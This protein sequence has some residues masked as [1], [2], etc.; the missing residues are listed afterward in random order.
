MPSTRVRKSLIALSFL[1]LFSGMASLAM[2]GVGQGSDQLLVQDLSWSDSFLSQISLNGTTSAG[3]SVIGGTLVVLP[4]EY[5][6]KLSAGAIFLALGT[7]SLERREEKVL[8]LRDR[9]VEEIS[10]N[11]GIHLR[12]L[13]RQVG[14][15]MGALQYHLRNL[16]RDGSVLSVRNG[17]A[18]HLFIRGYS[19][20]DQVLKLASMFTNPTIKSILD[21]CMAN[22]RITQAELSRTLSI[23]KSLVSYYVGGLLEED[24]LRTIK[25]FGREKP[26]V[27][28]DWAKSAITVNGLLVQ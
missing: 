2:S 15:A 16:E 11:P 1:F 24:V 26:L 25:V 6:I 20:D 18:R 5:N 7:I 17:N 4:M 10:Q 21:A 23:E 12:E 9:I 3:M 27:L 19:P 13:H 28:T 8:K 14:C 22:G